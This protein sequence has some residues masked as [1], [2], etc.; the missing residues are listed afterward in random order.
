VL[1]LCAAATRWIAYHLS[2]REGEHAMRWLVAM[3]GWL[4]V[5]SAVHA[6]DAAQKLYD[7]MEQKLAKAKAHQFNFAIDGFHDNSPIEWQGTVI[8]ADGN[9]LK[10]AFTEQDGNFQWHNTIVSDGKTLAEQV[11]FEG[12]QPQVRTA[13]VEKMLVDRV[14]GHLSPIGA[15]FGIINIPRE[16]RKAALLKLS[17][18]KMAGKEKVGGR[19]A[20]IIAYQFPFGEKD[21]PTTCKLWLDAQ[22]NL[23]LKRVLEISDQGKVLFRA[24][25]T[26]SGWELEPKLPEETFMLPK[27]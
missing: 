4:T 9:R 13:T 26:Y 7:A 25:E 12:T 20:N 16:S 15:Y 24:V 18:F 14:V 17:G 10:V 11:Q 21:L 6:Q 27:S 1:A 23:P 3:V 19:E 8:L 5:V 22:T 2:H